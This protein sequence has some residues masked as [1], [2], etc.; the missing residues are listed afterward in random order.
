MEYLIFLELNFK[1]YVYINVISAVILLK[2]Y[3]IVGGVLSNHRK[4]LNVGRLA[5]LFTEL[6]RRWIIEY[7]F[8]FEVHH[9]EPVF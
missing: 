1:R 3:V 7:S 4:K 9:L 2:M 6:Q 8:H 5:V